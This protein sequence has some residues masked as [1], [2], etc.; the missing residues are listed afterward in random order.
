MRPRPKP[1]HILTVQE[2]GEFIER[3]KNQR[4]GG[5]YVVTF[6]SLPVICGYNAV[7]KTDPEDD[8]PVR[9]TLLSADAKLGQA[10]IMLL[11]HRKSA[12]R[13]ISHTALEV[14]QIFVEV[15]G[16]TDKEILEAMQTTLMPVEEGLPPSSV[17]HFAE[18]Q[19]IGCRSSSAKL[20][21]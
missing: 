7:F 6:P 14:W 15:Y 12:D 4:Q 3:Y 17:L 2:M 21:P 18:D 9:V 8:D 5:K 20:H 10:E 13:H 19:L 11:K 16:I 1:D